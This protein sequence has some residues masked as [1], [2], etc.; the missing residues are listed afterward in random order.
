M[1]LTAYVSDDEGQTSAVLMLDE[2][3]GVSYPDGF[4][5]LRRHVLH[6]LRITGA[7]P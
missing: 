4:Q 5:H 1:H 2:R 6:H 3:T 7:G